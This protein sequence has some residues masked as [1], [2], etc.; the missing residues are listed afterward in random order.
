MRGRTYDCDFCDTGKLPMSYVRNQQKKHPN[1]I[2]LYA[3]HKC[4]ADMDEQ[5]KK[6]WSQPIARI[7]AMQPWLTVKQLAEAR[8]KHGITKTG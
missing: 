5:N 4:S 1:R 2:A 8:K 7:A 6:F 3:C